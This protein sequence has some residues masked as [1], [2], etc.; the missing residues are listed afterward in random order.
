MS[1][2]SALQR[3]IQYDY[4]EHIATN[5]E[6]LL[7][8][9]SQTVEPIDYQLQAT[10]IEVEWL[11]VKVPAK[12]A[13]LYP[14]FMRD[15]TYAISLEWF[16]NLGNQR[17]NFHIAG[18]PPIVGLE[19]D[20][21]GNFIQVTGVNLVDNDIYEVSGCSPAQLDYWQVIN[22]AM[23]TQSIN[24]TCADC[25]GEVITKTGMMGY[26]QADSLTYPNDPTTWGGLSCQPIRHH[27][28]PSNEVTHIHEQSTAIVL[29]SGQ[30]DCPTGNCRVDSL[31]FD[32]INESWSVVPEFIDC[33]SGCTQGEYIVYVE[34][35]GMDVPFVLR[36]D[37]CCNSS[38]SGGSTTEF[39]ED[40]CVNILA[41]RLKNIRRP[42]D[43][44]GNPIN[45]IAGYRILV[46]DRKGQK[47]IL[48]KGLIYNAW[49]DNSTNGVEIL[50]PNYPFN[51]LHADAFLTTE[52]TTDESGGSTP[53][54]P[55]V[56]TY[57][58]TDFTY[59]SPDIHFRESKQEFGTEM[60]YYGLEVAY[61]EG[62]FEWVYKHP[63]TNLGQ[64]NDVDYKKYAMQ[65]NSVANY[66]KFVPIP[67]Y[68]IPAI[69]RRYSIANAQYLLP[70]NQIL[71]NGKKFNN[72]L[73]ESS[74]YVQLNGTPYIN[75]TDNILPENKDRSRF[76]ASEVQPSTWDNRRDNEV[77]FSNAQRVSRGG[78]NLD[79]TG[80]I[81]ASS[82][83]VG[84]KIKKP[85]QYGSLEQINYRPVTC[86]NYVDVTGTYTSD[87]VY[88]G[89]VYISK[90]S[91]LRKM[92]IVKEW[93][94]DVPIGT[95]IDYRRYRNAWYPRF[96]YDDLGD[97]DRY[98]LD[99]IV[100]LNDSLRGGAIYIFVTGVISYWCESEF[101]ADFRE[102]DF[103]INGQYYPKISENDIARSDKIPFDNK[104]LYNFSLLNDEIERVKQNLDPT[105]SD[106]D[107]I[108]SYSLKDDQQGAGDRWLQ[109]LPLN[110]H[111]LPRNYG[112]FTGMHWVDQYSMFFIF[113]DQ[114][115]YSQVDFSLNLSQGSTVSLGEGDI[116]DN[117][118][119]KLSNENTGYVGSVDPMSFINSR[120]GTYFIDRK[121]KKIFRWSGKL[122]DVTDT[123]GSWLNR[124][125]T[126]TT[127]PGYSNSMIGVFDNFS[128]N[129]FYT[130]KTLGWTLSIKPEIG[131]ISF[132][133]FVP[134]YYLSL[135][136]TF[137]TYKDFGFWTH[138]KGLYQTYY[139]QQAPFIVGLFINLQYQNSEIQNIELFSEWI[140]YLDYDS[141]IYT[142]S[143]FFDKMFLYNNNGSTG[144]KNLVLR[145]RNNPNQVQNF[146]DNVE[147]SLVN[148]SVFR[149]NKLES[150]R[151]NPETTSPILWNPN[152]I[153]YVESGVDPNLSPLNRED[154]KGKWAVL[155]L[156]SDTN[157]ENKILVQLLIPNID[158]NTV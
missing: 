151:V 156:I 87:I 72:Y 139:G 65:M 50:Y 53:N 24:G 157:S 143:K 110:Y 55:A 1:T 94:Y 136:N 88:G 133:S 4:S 62:K 91:L 122:E 97:N 47:T 144:I 80:T 51:D 113:E 124:Y 14:S 125:L 153:T 41:I 96:W 78:V 142:K 56:N 100:S 102:Q 121:R 107:F 69:H 130:N 134:K 116:F 35:D 117:R 44:D 59:H 140:K 147:V 20:V 74:Y 105:L 103:T 129:L 5:G 49:K 16:D 52:Q 106:G 89:D 75:W 135:P 81:Q 7:L 82:Y 118:L 25:S 40:E 145:D 112:K 28:M 131:P 84:I 33:P 83:Y 19:I 150:I 64:V 17:G 71:S 8:G 158:K 77:S 63:E 92:P 9:D 85:D 48:H 98:R 120:F 128:K 101:I 108:V 93:L 68:K 15:E 6:T 30:S 67:N 123:L 34:E 32:P 18:R 46:S 12:N 109:F 79:G 29:P 3:K 99:S 31:V 37:S 13:N 90:H 57:S 23:V 26:W 10:G 45:D 137:I 58:I 95:E 149:F 148:D 27:R 119:L 42:V 61:V 60:K 126:F 21:S 70:V 127:Y 2:S 114:I 154:I 11:E 22:T 155:H 111:I 141:P 73:R 38:P 132:H 138:N 115:L 76:L 86:I 43:E 66:N 54:K 146:S 39:S 152:G 36:D 104:F